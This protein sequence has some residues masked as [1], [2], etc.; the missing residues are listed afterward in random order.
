MAIF[1][2]V[3]SV[4]ELASLLIYVV[5]DKMIAT[6]P[7]E[8][9]QKTS[10]TTAS[11]L[12]EQSLHALSEAVDALK[13]Q[14]DNTLHS[15]PFSP[16][17]GDSVLDDQD[18]TTDKDAQD[19]AD[20]TAAPASS[21]VTALHEVANL[22]SASDFGA[23]YLNYLLYVTFGM[24]AI[25]IGFNLTITPLYILEQFQKSPGLIGIILAARSAAGNLVGIFITLVP[26][27]KSFMQRFIPSPNDL[28][29]TMEGISVSVFL[30][31]IPIFPVHIIGLL[32]LM[33]FNDAASIILSGMQGE[34]TSAKA[35]SKIGPWAK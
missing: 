2:I 27:G 30:A 20:T 12:G 13:M 4:L 34:I 15:L 22:F 19:D 31:A 25:T 3:L 14:K 18:T 21:Q 23:N 1:G 11:E 32:L 6:N 24:E 35:Y 28:F 26:T 5:L 8:T 10:G 7:E 29:L 9:V 33:A 16:D 17:D